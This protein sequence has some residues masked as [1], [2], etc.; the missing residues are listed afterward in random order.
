MELLET[1]FDLPGDILGG[2]IGN[3][4]LGAFQVIINLICGLLIGCLG[5]IGEVFLKAMAVKPDE[6]DTWLGAAL[7]TGSFAETITI[8]GML[9][10]ALFAMWELCRGLMAFIQGDNAPIRPSVVLIRFIIFGSWTYAGIRFSKVIFG[11]GSKIYDAVPFNSLS[12]GLAETIW[13][14]FSSAAVSIG[15]YLASNFAALFGSYDWA[16]ELLG[17]VMASALLIFSMSGFLKLL[18]TCSQRYVNMIFYTYFSPLAIACGVSS[19]WSKITWTWLKT[20]LST[21]VLWVLDIWCIFGGYNLLQAGLNALSNQLDLIGA[22]SCMLVT[23]GFMKGAIAFDGIM[24]QFGATVT[25]TT[26]SLMGDVRDMMILSHAASGVARTISGISSGVGA[27]IAQGNGVGT[28]SKFSNLGMDKWNTGKARNGWEIARDAAIAGF[29]ATGV[30]RTALSAID[31]IAGMS[32]KGM[33]AINENRN[34]KRGQEMFN[35][36]KRLGEN[37]DI[38]MGEGPRL[39]GTNLAGK[40]TP[41]RAAFD[42][43]LQDIIDDYGQKGISMK[44]LYN[45]PNVLDEMGKSTLFD[46][47]HPEFGSMADNGFQ[48][49]GYNPGQNGIGKAMFDKRDK[50]GNLLE[51]REAKHLR[52]G[53]VEPNITGTAKNLKNGMTAGIPTGHQEMFSGDITST[54]ITPTN[55]GNGY[56][57]T[58]VDQNG[59]EMNKSINTIRGKNMDNSQSVLVTTRDS[60]GVPISQDEY[61]LKNGKTLR[62]AANAFASGNLDAAFVTQKTKDGAVEPVVTA[63]NMFDGSN[64]NRSSYSPLSNPKGVM[65]FSKGTMGAAV[66]DTNDKNSRYVVNASQPD[67]NGMVTLA[68][69]SQNDPSKVVARGSISADDLEA[70]YNGGGE[71][72]NSAINKAFN[73]PKQEDVPA[74]N[75]H[76]SEARAETSS[77]ASAPAADI[78]TPPRQTENVTMPAEDNQTMARHIEN[79]P[80]TSTGNSP[81]VQHSDNISAASAEETISTPR[82]EP[83]SASGVEGPT[84]AHRVENAPASTVEGPAETPHVENAPANQAQAQTMAP[85][86]PQAVEYQA[87][88]QQG[89]VP[90]PMEAPTPAPS[91]NGPDLAPNMSATGPAQTAVGNMTEATQESQNTQGNTIVNQ[92]TVQH[93]STSTGQADSVK[94]ETRTETRTTGTESHG[95]KSEVFDM[96][97]FESGEQNSDDQTAAEESELAT[98]QAKKAAHDRKVKKDDGISKK[99]RRPRHNPYQ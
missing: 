39:A 72:M 51:R 6:I 44:D 4:I 10:A 88:P 5:T 43:D 90:T 69:V 60:Q 41:E 25:K 21:L 28:A 9:I 94:T 7:T 97:E 92:T 98:K 32:K 52:Y 65:T 58:G 74:A 59:H 13:T 91:T 33:Q 18:F 15:T 85:D 96:L 57:I 86:S 19:S 23:Y 17:H 24:S 53:Y 64:V 66:K 49:V 99:F 93:D 8:S 36:A 45:D 30:G 3:L 75:V 1:I 89:T 50:N 73:P 62:D 46:P 70:A 42:K 67:E 68:A 83:A 56:D 48:C 35:M 84:A 26:G 77:S 27:A 22:L 37:A 63:H 12:Y 40:N 29:S 20:M 11:I 38:N 14:M 95:K 31:G 82:A 81:V 78:S 55:Q 61:T 80:V 2:T 79:E 16:T 34:S 54:K 76:T 87:Q 47:Q 71:V